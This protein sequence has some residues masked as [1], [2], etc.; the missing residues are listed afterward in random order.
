MGVRER[1]RERE[2][3]EINILNKSANITHPDTIIEILVIK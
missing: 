2:R 1:E 3:K